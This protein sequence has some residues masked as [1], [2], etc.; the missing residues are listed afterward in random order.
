MTVLCSC[1]NPGM[2]ALPN[3]RGSIWVSKCQAGCNCSATAAGTHSNYSGKG[4]WKT[5][6]NLLAAGAVRD[7]DCLRTTL[8]GCDCYTAHMQGLGAFMMGMLAVIARQQS[9]CKVMLTVIAAN[10]AAV[11]HVPQLDSTCNFGP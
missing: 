10:D 8:Q 7:F 3:Q 9:M 11:C 1:C 2:H 5:A 6:H 4:S